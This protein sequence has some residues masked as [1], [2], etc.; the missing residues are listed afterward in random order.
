[1][2]VATSPLTN[3]KSTNRIF[4][5]FCVSIVLSLGIVN[6]SAAPAQRAYS[7]GSLRSMARV[8]MACGGYEK[9]QPLLERALNLAKKTKTADS[10]MC[11]CMIDLAYLYKNQSKLAEAETMCQ[12]GL[13]LQQKVN[14]QNHP[15]V[16]YT[17]RILS[18]IYGRQ[19]RYQEAVETLER[20]LTIMRGFTLEDDQ[21]LAPFKVDMAR[22]LAAQGDYE[23]AESYFKNA[24]AS[25]EKSYGADHLYT[26]KVCSSMASLYAQQGRYAEAEELISKAL[27]IQ[28]RVYGPNHHLL[29][30]VW[31][32]KSR[33]YE[34]KGDLLNTKVFLEKSLGAVENQ[35]DS[36]YL[37][38]CDVLSRFGEFYL[39]GK[40]YSK[41]EDVLQRALE[42]LESSQGTNNRTAIALN[43][44]AKVYIN[45]GKYSKAQNL[46]GRALDI[47]E[48][49]FDE[50]HPSVAD[51]LETLVQLHRKTGNMTEVAR[52][53]QRVEEIR[54]HK[55]VAYAPVAKAVQ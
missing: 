20:A 4:V 34:A 28:E 19:A 13:E 32:V 49:I 52:L 15:Y 14:G 38:E 21:E 1:M 10:E 33:I 11:A 23:K 40:K 55:R 53:E 9:A 31:L 48:N 22:L 50:Y 7:S 47:L 35:A 18:E 29:I 41:A 24:I 5:I 39:L 44:L 36:G 25:I 30:P 26:A 42:V 16:A 54:V 51:V 45:Q 43:S 37:V 46:C 6:A 17:L 12:R 8:Y 27:P 3:R 2:V